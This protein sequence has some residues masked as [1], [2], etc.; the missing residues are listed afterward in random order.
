MKRY[1]LESRQFE[2]YTRHTYRTEDGTVHVSYELEEPHV[3]LADIKALLNKARGRAN[4]R[5]RRARHDP[6][7][8]D[9]VLAD[10]EAGMTQ[11]AVA[12]KHRISTK[13]IN[14]YKTGIRRT[15]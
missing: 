1:Y 6:D 4:L 7:R 14:A 2:N 5:P 9:A 11:T 12:A 8:V 15:S 13:T 3:N 10:L